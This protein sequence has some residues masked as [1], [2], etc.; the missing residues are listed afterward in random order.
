ARKRRQYRTTGVPDALASDW[1][2]ALL[3]ELAQ[4]RDSDCSGILC[5]LYAG[6]TWAA[7]HFGLRSR[8]TLHYWFPVYNVE[9][10]K[11]APGHC[12]IGQIIDESATNGIRVID[13]GE[14]DHSHKAAWFT[15]QQSFYRGVWSLPN[16]KALVYRT[17][18]GLTW[19]LRA[20][21][22]RSGE[23]GERTKE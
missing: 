13:R 9:L 3:L 16:A 23:R 20:L 4:S 22:P 12:L 6:E 14:G 18:L 10:A 19:R 5:E 1:K 2:R 8:T 11:F 21:A 7:S 17:Q 15:E